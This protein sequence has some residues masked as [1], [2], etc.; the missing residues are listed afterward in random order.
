MGIDT[1]IYVRPRTGISAWFDWLQMLTG[2]GLILFMWSHMVMVASVNLGTGVMNSLAHFL[3]TTY[4]AQIGGPSGGCIPAEHLDTPVSYL[5]YSVDALP[6]VDV[7]LVSH[8]HYDHLD[9]E[10]VIALG[11]RLGLELVV[12]GIE[13]ATVQYDVSQTSSFPRTKIATAMVAVSPDNG[14]V[15]VSWRQFETDPTYLVCASGGGYWKTHPQSWDG[16]GSDDFTSTI[17]A[18]MPFNATLGV[19]PVEE[20]R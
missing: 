20:M 4:M 2:V 18:A 17:F 5:P 19:T 10:T 16:V 14:D 7:V 11:N 13:R 3:E 9:H 12:E 6:A 8:D 15:W 1:T